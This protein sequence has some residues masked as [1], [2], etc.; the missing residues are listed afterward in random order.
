MALHGTEPDLNAGRHTVGGSRI[1]LPVR[2]RPARGQAWSRPPR[3]SSQPSRSA[4][5]SLA[6]CPCAPLRDSLV[7]APV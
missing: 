6:G 5:R 4:H 2:N 3:S 7:R 1:G